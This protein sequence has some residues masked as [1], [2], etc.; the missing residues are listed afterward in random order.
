MAKILN[1]GITK[2]LDDSSDSVIYG[3]VDDDFIEEI[4]FDQRT[5]QFQVDIYKEILGIPDDII[6][7]TNIFSSKMNKK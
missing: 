6:K 3:D 4:C 5:P 1:D 2:E 7:S